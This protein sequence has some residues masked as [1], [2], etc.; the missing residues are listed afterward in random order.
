[1][2]KASGL[3]FMFSPATAVSLR[4]ST[5]DDGIVDASEGWRSDQCPL[6]RYSSRSVLDWSPEV[7]ESVRQPPQQTLSPSDAAR[8]MQEPEPA[9]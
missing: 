7:P 9:H 2:P 6:Q 4:I 3:N 8:P 1:M 5:A